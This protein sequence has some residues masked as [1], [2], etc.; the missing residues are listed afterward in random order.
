MK[1]LTRRGGSEYSIPCV[2]CP[3][4]LVYSTVCGSDA[5]W[6]AR[7]LQGCSLH[8]QPGAGPWCAAATSCVC[9]GRDG[10]DRML[11][12]VYRL[13]FGLWHGA[14]TGRTGRPARTDRHRAARGA[15]HETRGPSTFNPDV[16][17]VIRSTTVADEADQPRSAGPLWSLPS[18]ES[19][20]KHSSYP[21]CV[22]RTTPF[23]WV[24]LTR[25]EMLSSHPADHLASSGAH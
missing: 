3:A 6:L 14:R 2:L 20:A 23:R 13:Q 24:V 18:Y 22:R 25:P 1:T 16:I 15:A 12:T 9:T 10:G 8:V 19:Q 5:L 4:L 17:M 21:V 11:Y 7:R